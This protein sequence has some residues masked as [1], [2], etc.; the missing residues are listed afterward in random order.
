MIIIYIF[1]YLST[2][3]AN[4]SIW[5][6]TLHTNPIFV[7]FYSDKNYESLQMLKTWE[8]LPSDQNVNIETYNCDN[9]VF[10]LCHYLNEIPSIQM[11]EPHA[12]KTYTGKRNLRSLKRFI[13][14]MVPLCNVDTGAFCSKEQQKHIEEWSKNKEKYRAVLHDHNKDIIIDTHKFEFGERNLKKKYESLRKNFTNKIKKRKSEEN[15]GL[16]QRFI[17]FHSKKN[18]L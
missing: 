3:L 16:L 14:K 7:L 12:F 10:G 4:D 1:L 17:W 6:T 8:K 9:D 18:E 2:V 11:G 15:I 13:K 5:T